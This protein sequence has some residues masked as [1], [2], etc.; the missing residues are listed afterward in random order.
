MSVNRYTDNQKAAIYA[1]GGAL[2][3]ASAG[4]GKTSVLVERVMDKILN[5]GVPIERLLI[6]TFTNAAAAEMRERIEQSLNDA[7]KENPTSR[8]IANQKQRL[9]MAKI[10]TVD[11]FCI[12]LIR[13]NFDAIGVM[14]DFTVCDP[15]G[16]V[17][18]QNQAL[19]EVLEPMF[20]QNSDEFRG[21]LQATGDVYG[22]DKLKDYVKSIYNYVNNMPFYTDWLKKWC[23]Y[24]DAHSNFEGTVWE[25]LL[26]AETKKEFER[27]SVIT[28]NALCAPKIDL[29]D[30]AIYKASLTE[31][32]NE[33]DK[34]CELCDDSKELMQA[35]LEGKIFTFDQKRSAPAL[36]LSGAVREY[37]QVIEKIKD[38]FGGDELEINER[39]R[40]TAKVSKLLVDLVL[41]FDERFCELTRQANT[42]TFAQTEQL[43]LQL[44]CKNGEQGF[45]STERGKEIADDFDEIIVDEYQDTNDLQDALMQ[46]LSDNGKRLFVVGDAKQSIYE[47]RG[48]NPINFI[49]K[50]DSGKL[51]KYMLHDNFRSVKPICD[52]INSVFCDLM[53]FE[54]SKI[55]Y[56]EQ[57][58][59]PADQ[60][61][62]A[63]VSVNFHSS[64]GINA[65]DAAKNEA[66]LIAQYIKNLMQSGEYKYSDFTVLKRSSKRME[67]YADTLCEYGVPAYCNRTESVNKREIALCLALLSVVDNPTKDEQLLAVMMSPLF[68]FTADS[69]AL[70]RHDYYA[71]SIW[72]SVLLAAKDG[73]SQCQ[74]LYERIKEFR[75]LSLVNTLPDF[76]SLLI[77][78]TG[79][80]DIARAMQGGEQRAKNLRAL[81]RMA[82]EY[83]KNN[84]KGIAGFVNSVSEGALSLGIAADDVDAVKITT[85]HSSKGLGFPVCIIANAA[86]TFEGGDKHSF[87]IKNSLGLACDAVGE[88]LSQKIISPAREAI[89]V[90]NANDSIAE[91]LRLMYVFMTRAK[92]KL[93]IF[94]SYSNFA[95]RLKE[96]GKVVKNNGQMPD[97]KR[98]SNYM[99]LILQSLAARNTQAFERLKNVASGGTEVIEKVEYTVHSDIPQPEF[100]EISNDQSVDYDKVQQAVQTIENNLNFEYEFERDTKTASKISVSELTH[101]EN[102]TQYSFAKRPAFLSK[103]QLTPAQRGTATHLFMQYCNMEKA[104]QNAKEELDRLVEY[105]FMTEQ[106]GDAVDLNAIKAFFESDLYE[107]ICNAQKLYREIRF[108][109]KVYPDGDCFA[110]PTILQG[111]ADCVFIENDELVILDF[112]TDRVSDENKLVELYAKQLELYA[113]ACEKTFE[114]PVKECIIYSFVLKKA[115]KI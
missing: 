1:D 87:S 2:V 90:K 72:A 95:D 5:K 24:Y 29:P 61:Q 14:P 99:D 17:A 13:E 82:I 111:V 59:K 46:A 80:D 63:A 85:M 101:K 49:N 84:D 56:K 62:E 25:E 6:V 42:L 67:I 4:S 78:Q 18:L 86:D 92:K 91:E 22:D 31:L 103:N 107:R 88:K 9:A 75:R 65:D 70:L 112:K 77:E 106:Q 35:V 12:E 16:V 15:S 55:D 105:Q 45:V 83:A 36:A 96:I 98:S 60:S 30:F 94:A 66:A 64:K 108:L 89:K 104:K 41:K 58:L 97:P 44:L 100:E 32:K 39:Y 93:A 71:P 26:L 69:L 68:S 43:A 57:F 48:T 40:F 47:F 19:S 76:V 79:L 8:L 34:L 102:D 113:M 110:E 52:F 23:D 27:L 38:W 54:N 20:E 33:I 28:S 114:K 51:Q 3:T 53:T 81:Q 21:L 109:T 50:S 73:N 74:E 115:I 10:C 37:N 7:Q 11:S